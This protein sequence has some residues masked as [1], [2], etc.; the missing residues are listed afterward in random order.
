[1]PLTLRLRGA[2]NE[3]ALVRSLEELHRR[4]ESLRTRFEARDGGAV[5]VIDPPGLG[6]TVEAVPA[7]EVEAIAHAE[8]SY[9]FDLSRERLCRVRLLRETVS[10]EARATTCCW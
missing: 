9:C 5:Q 7:P 1:M 2:T 10:D 4:H 3:A 8:R 6:L